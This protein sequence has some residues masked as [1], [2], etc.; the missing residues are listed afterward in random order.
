MTILAKDLGI[1]LSRK[2]QGVHEILIGP[3]GQFQSVTK[4]VQSID[5]LYK[6]SKGGLRTRIRVRM[7][8]FGKTSPLLFSLCFI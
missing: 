4:E 3:V 1:P 7:R 6:P 8:P 5:N 2:I